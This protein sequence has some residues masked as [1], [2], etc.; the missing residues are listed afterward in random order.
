MTEPGEPIQ[1]E[2]HYPDGALKVRWS[3]VGEMRHGL[4]ESFHPNG[5]LAER[6]VF[7]NGKRT[8]IWQGWD[9]T[10]RQMFETSAEDLDAPSAEEPDPTAWDEPIVAEEPLVDATPPGQ[11]RR[12]WI[13]AAV[14]LGLAWLAP[15]VTSLQLAEVFLSADLP[16][17]STASVEPIVDD[18]WFVSNAIATIAL[19][20]QVLI[21][22]MWIASRSDITWKG[23]NL[24]RFKPMR[25]FALGVVLAVGA[26]TVDW[27]FVAATDAKFDN[28][29]IMPSGAAG[30]ALLGPMMLANSL[31]EEFVWRGFLLRRFSQLFGSAFTGLLVSSFLFASYHLYQGSAGF[32][33]AAFSGLIWGAATLATRSLWPAVVAHTLFNIYATLPGAWWPE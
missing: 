20:L 31:Y 3:E 15:F 30:Y 29:V 5:M 8:G 11:K 9:E 18:R 22:L 12:W 24:P 1:R 16:G 13:E 25:D 10:G 21:P 33:L 17:E 26:L 27:I 14:V 28:I 2:E 4:F 19:S 7:E 32:V 6:G 23:M